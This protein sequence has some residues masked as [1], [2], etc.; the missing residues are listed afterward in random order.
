MMERMSMKKKKQDQREKKLTK[1][2]QAKN[3]NQEKSVQVLRKV[4]GYFLKSAWKKSKLYFLV[5]FGR[6]ITAVIQPFVSLLIIPEIIEELMGGRDVKVLMRLVLMIVIIN[7]VLWILNG[8]FTSINE[9][10]AQKF[11]NYYTT[12]LSERIIGLDFR[13]TE[14]KKALDQLELAR[15]G[16]SWYSGGLNGLVD[17]LFSLVSSAITLVG[18]FWLIVVKAP[19][20]LLVTAVILS[21]TAVVNAKLNKIEQ[22]GYAKLS[23]INRIFNYLGW[24]LTD[25]QYGKEIRLYHAKDMMIDKWSYFTEEMNRNWEEIANKQLPLKLLNVLTTLVRDFGTYVYLG[26]LAILGKITIA[27][28]TQMINAAG[29]FSNTL[30]YM[31]ACY[32]EMIKRANY[33]NEFVKFL[34]FPMEMHQGKLPVP[35]GVHEFEFMNLSFSYPGS[36]V[37][38]LDQV[39][40]KLRSGEHLSVVGLNG[41]GKTTLIKLLCRLYDPTEGEIRMD[42][43]NIKDYDYEQYMAVF[44]PV[45]QDF[46][47]FSFPAGENLV[48][49]EDRSEQEEQEICETLKQVG[50]YDKMMSFPKGLDTILYKYFDED[51]IEPSGGEQQKLA[52]ARALLK[53]AGVI[54]LDEPTAALDPYAEYE[55]YL[56]FEKMVKGKTA[57]YISHRLSSCQFCDRIVVFQDGK[58]VQ[59]GSHAELLKEK[60]GLY[61]GMWNAQAQ[62]YI[63][64]EEE[65]NTTCGT[66]LNLT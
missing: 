59:C 10:Y 46:R 12:V 38:A 61:A 52:I 51:G 40:L 18:V 47:L 58:M 20:V 15:N 65:G 42:G 34:D 31:V 53:H 28:T 6:L 17:H 64:K 43:I 25:F 30:I 5:R 24:K 7:F 36:D 19:M 50:I 45:F 13:L 39:N 26:I 48:L 62:Y 37:K 29:T 56:Q 2:K 49:K 4:Y 32:Q 41:A 14:D 44:A 16:M 27:T 9:W 54:I 33:A 55:I 66:Y 22:E 3:G 60:D 57:V 1:N 35:E 8:T 11:E 21:V 63:E 23:K